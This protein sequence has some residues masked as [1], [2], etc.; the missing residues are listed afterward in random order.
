MQEYFPDGSVLIP[1]NH[2]KSIKLDE[3]A[4]EVL[5]KEVLIAVKNALDNF[6]DMREKEGNK[7]KIDLE[8]RIKSITENID[9]ISKI[10]TGLVDEYIV[11]LETLTGETCIFLWLTDLI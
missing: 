8:E 2:K 7:I 9:K 4:E 3:D 6:I 10:S 11:K 1:Q 5:E